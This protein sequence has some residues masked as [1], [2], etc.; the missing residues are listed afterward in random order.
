MRYSFSV[1]AGVPD[2]LPSKDAPAALPE[3]WRGIPPL[4][5]SRSII[6]VHEN[7]RC[8]LR[9]RVDYYRLQGLFGRLVD[10]RKCLR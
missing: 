4:P 5:Q 9:F 10:E 8:R 7:L 1:A 6:A 2:S 3:S